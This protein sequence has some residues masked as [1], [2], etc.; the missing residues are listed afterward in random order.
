[1]D[2]DSII[3]KLFTFAGYTYGPLLGL[4][5]FGMFTKRTLK[6]NLVFPVCVAAPI[7]T[8]FLNMGLSAVG[9]N[10][11]FLLLALNGLLAFLGLLAISKK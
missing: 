9:V 11:G 5:T 3:N 7:L 8:Y 10:V 2:D 6:N 4:F 1:M